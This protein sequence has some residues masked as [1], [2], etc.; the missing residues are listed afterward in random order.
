MAG[1]AWYYGTVKR[2]FVNTSDGFVLM[3]NSAALDDCQYEYVYYKLS[4]LG[5]KKVDRAYSMA[6]AAQASG[7][8]LGVVIDKAINGPGGQCASSGAMD[9]KD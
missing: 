5:D 1:S 4:T 8:T 7:R 9:I 2:I 3:M 6:L